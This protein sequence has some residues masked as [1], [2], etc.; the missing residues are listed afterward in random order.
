MAIRAFAAPVLGLLSD[1]DG[2]GQPVLSV[3]IDLDPSRFTTPAARQAQLGSLLA[4]ARH[5]AAAKDLERVQP[6]IERVHAL[7][8]DDPTVARGSRALAVFSCAATG[9]F[10]VVRLPNPVEPMAVVDTVPW[11]E[12]LAEI[13]SPEGW[14]V[15]VINR[16]DAKL[17]RGGPRGLVQFALISDDLHRRHAQGGWSQSR[18]QRGIEEQVAW[19]VQRVADR[20]LRA[21]HRV[22]F[23][24][25]AF[26]ASQEIRPVIDRSLHR[27]LKAVLAGTVDA[28]LGRATPQDLAR[29][30][31]PLIDT[32]QREREQ[33]LATEI[34]EALGTGG[35]AAAGIDEVLAMLEQ[36]RVDT[37]LVPPRSSHAQTI[38]HA[39]D[40]AGRQSVPVVVMHYEADWLLAH[41]GIAARLR[42]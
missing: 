41:G 31:G 25:L 9:V 32:A 5:N 42:Y 6:D 40:E 7:L 37:L 19:H 38:E 24:H 17:F 33:A 28:D 30:V 16:R 3:Y 36:R 12:P 27:D 18:F 13:V 22:P 35:A 20:L 8:R 14:G 21:H 15:A 23:A 11:L 4:E 10:E 29:V 2:D 26:I 1:I 34:D 39:V